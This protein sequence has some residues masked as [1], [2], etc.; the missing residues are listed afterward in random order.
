MKPFTLIISL[1]LLAGCATEPPLVRGKSKDWVTIEWA[2]KQV[3][4]AGGKVWTQAADR[5]CGL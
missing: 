2:E 3:C 5:E 1:A 4:Q